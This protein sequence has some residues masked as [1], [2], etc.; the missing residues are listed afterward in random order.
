[1]TLLVC[2]TLPDGTAAVVTPVAGPGESDAFA[3][4]RVLAQLLPDR[5]DATV[6]PAGLVAA[7]RRADTP[8]GSAVVS[9]AE[10]LRRTAVLYLTLPTAAVELQTKWDRILGSPLLAFDTYDLT[11][12]VLAGLV[13]TAQADGLLTAEQAAAI[14]APPP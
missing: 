7:L 1:M 5:P 13:G 11:D 2:H 4:A 6:I 8:A 9:R 3:A 12:P 14:L 10:F